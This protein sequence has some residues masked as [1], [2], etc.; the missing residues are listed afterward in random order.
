MNS[1]FYIFWALPLPYS[2]LRP[3]TSRVSTVWA[4]VIV[5]CRAMYQLKWV[6]PSAY[7]SNCT[8]VSSVGAAASSWPDRRAPGKGRV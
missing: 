2:T 7:A 5:V 8:Q 6:V 1:V 3:F 4:C